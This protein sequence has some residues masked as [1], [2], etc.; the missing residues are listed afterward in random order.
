MIYIIYTF[1]SLL[2]TGI[3]ELALDLQLVERRTGIA[4]AMGA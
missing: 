2:T 1:H 3:N 4:K